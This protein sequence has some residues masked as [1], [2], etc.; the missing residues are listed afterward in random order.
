MAGDIFEDHDRVIDHDTDDYGKGREGDRIQG[1]TKKI[2]DQKR[3]AKS[4]R[5]G[6]DHIDR[7]T[8]RAQEKPADNAGE[9]DG[10][11]DRELH[12]MECVADLVRAVKI[13]RKLKA[14]GQVGREFLH[15]FFDALCDLHGIRAALFPDPDADGRFAQHAGF[16]PDIFEAVLDLRDIAQAECFPEIALANPAR[17]DQV[18]QFLDVC[19]FSHYPD[20]SFGFF[21]RE[22]PCRKFRVLRSDGCEHVF[23]G[24]FQRLKFFVIQP[25]PHAGFRETPER[26]LPDVRDN[27]KLVLE[28]VFDILNHFPQRAVAREAEPDDRLVVG[29]HLGNDR[30][31][32]VFGKVSLRLRD[33]G[34]NLLNCDVDIL[35]QLKFR[36]D[37]GAAKTG[38]GLDILDLF[39]GHESFLDDVH[40]FG[41]HHLGRGALPCHADIRIRKINVRHLRDTHAKEADPAEDQE[42]GHDHP[43]ENGFLDR[44]VRKLHVISPIATRIAAS[45]PFIR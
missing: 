39:D 6:D 17:N 42:G 12:F 38:S 28:M 13:D 15:P 32:H 14:F 22:P 8:Q 21:R 9:D 23:S 37:A 40:H 11:D 19:R 25:Y 10:Q 3:S 27:R 7:G 43:R 24:Q 16:P 41:F 20:V 26:Y 31:V 35:G 2:H 1:K 29:V 4:G 44:N 33:L 45:L 18:A 34:L 30:R 5:D 36:S